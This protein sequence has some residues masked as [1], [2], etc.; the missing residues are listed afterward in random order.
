MRRHTALTL[1]SPTPSSKLAVLPERAEGD[2]PAAEDASVFVL[3][4]L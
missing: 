2:V 3:L 1:F 4:Y